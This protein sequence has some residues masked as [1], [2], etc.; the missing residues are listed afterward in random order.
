METSISYTTKDRAYVSS[1]ERKWINRIRI[2]Q[3]KYPGEVYIL[4]QPE[5]NDG[6]IYATVPVSYVKIQPKRQL[7]EEHI[8]KLRNNLGENLGKFRAESEE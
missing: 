7:S 8:Q 6:C 1:D 2:L 3:K 5:E 4:K